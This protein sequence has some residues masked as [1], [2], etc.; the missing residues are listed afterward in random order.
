MVIDLKFDRQN[1]SP[2]L[3]D[4]MIGKELEQ[5]DTRTDP[6][7]GRKKKKLSTYSKYLPRP[8]E[9]PTRTEPSN[10]G[11]KANR[12]QQ[13]NPTMGLTNHS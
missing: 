13:R 1:C 8:A 10:D 2:I 11:A 12:S 4:I 9:K 5:I 3:R 6:E 7:T